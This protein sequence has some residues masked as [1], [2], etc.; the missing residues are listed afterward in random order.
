MIILSITNGDEQCKNY[1]SEEEREHFLSCLHRFFIWVGEP[2]PETVDV[3]G[4][5]VKLR[6][7]VW[8]CIHEK[9]ISEKEKS[10]F[11]EL[12]ELLEN[13]EEHDKELLQKANLTREEAKKLYHEIASLIRAIMDIR[14]CEAGKVKLKEPEI[15][16]KIEDTKRW[17]TFLKSAKKT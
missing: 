13:K 16:Q 15:I 14:E 3:N 10:D 9:E 8:N 1:I 4:E 11:L 5:K 7:L 12:I 2:L 6:E 17:I